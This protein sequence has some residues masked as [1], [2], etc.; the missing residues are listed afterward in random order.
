MAETNSTTAT[1][2]TVVNSPFDTTAPAPVTRGDKHLWGIYMALCAISLVELYSASS[3]EV[4]ASSIGVMGPVIRH[5]AMLIGGFGIM[6]LISRKHYRIVILMTYVIATIS[7]LMM[8]YVMVAGEVVNGARRSMNILGISIQPAELIKLSSVLIVALQMARS[9]KLKSIGV[10][11]KGVFWAAVFITFF[12]AMLLPQGL[13]NTF[14]LMFISI[15]MMIIGGTPWKRIL[16]VIAIYGVAGGGYIGYVW[17]T[18]NPEAGKLSRMDTWIARIERFSDPTPKYEQEI[19]LENRQEMYSYMAQAHG[20]ISGVLPG[21]SREASR[22]PL[23][24]S[25]F[26]YSIIIEDL[27]VWGGIGVLLLYLWL[28]GRAAAIASRCSRSYP[29]LL[30]IGMAVMVV[31]Q[32]LIHMAIVT[33]AIPVSGQPLPLISKGGSSILVTSIA[34]GIMLSV[35]RFAANNKAKRQVIK[36]EINALPEEMSAE[37]PTQL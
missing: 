36:D 2:S 12:G 7:I 5:V 14:L 15:G 18:D 20:G 1:A 34:F 35:S 30:V 6:W 27:G 33:G 28:L 32:A 37:N 3:R 29:A 4:N 22:L 13:T 9:Q 11:D 24:F 16:L 8:G 25:D 17:L 23:A 10:K 31:A 19:N 26:I 21:N